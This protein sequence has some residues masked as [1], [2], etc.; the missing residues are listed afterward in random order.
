MV[1]KLLI[2]E[3]LVEIGFKS[4]ESDPL[5]LYPL[6]GYP[7]VN[8]ILYVDDALLLGKRNA[9]S[10]WSLPVTARRGQ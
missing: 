3:H 2:H 8:S 5:R 1:V 10:E 6:G 9:C 4:L 7:I